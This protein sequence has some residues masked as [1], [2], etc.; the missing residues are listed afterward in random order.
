MPHYPW[1]KDT[2]GT[3][4]YAELMDDETFTY[5]NSC[6][7]AKTVLKKKWRFLRSSMRLLEVLRF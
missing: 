4:K 2:M 1:L 3:T 5:Q 7:D 6:N